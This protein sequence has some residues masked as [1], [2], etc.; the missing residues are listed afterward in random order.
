[1]VRARDM[2]E[3]RDMVRQALLEVQDLGHAAEFDEMAE[4]GDLVSRLRES[5]ET[6]LASLEDGSYEFGKDA[7]GFLP[8]LEAHDVDVLPF[9]HLL[10]RINQTHTDGL[11]PSGADRA[12]IEENL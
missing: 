10:Q 8:L 7:L 5:L 9:R 6:L 1:M 3:Y 12:A 11:D 2:A 4:V